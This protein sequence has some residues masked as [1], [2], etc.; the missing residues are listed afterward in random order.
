MAKV[1]VKTDNFAKRIIKNGERAKRRALFG[2]ASATRNELRN[3]VK[4]KR[5]GPS[6]ADGKSAPHDHG[7]YRNTALF[8]VDSKGR[9]FEAGFASFRSSNKNLVLAGS[10]ALAQDNLEFGAIIRKKPVRKSR[11]SSFPDRLKGK[12]FPRKRKK[13]QVLNAFRIVQRPHVFVARE[14]LFKGST[15]NQRRFLKA[16]QYLIDRGYL[17]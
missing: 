13:K 5:K 12:Y 4:R 16:Q 14:R 3:V 17:K 2:M 6:K 15:K 8:S 7:T 11:G 10:T 9:G 1:I